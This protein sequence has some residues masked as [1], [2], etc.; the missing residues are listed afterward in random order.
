MQTKTCLACKV[1]KTEGNFYRSNNS[2]APDKRSLICVQCSS[3]LSETEKTRIQ[4]AEWRKNNPERSRANQQHGHFLKTY[5]IGLEE[6]E[7]RLKHQNGVCAI[8]K[9]PSSTRHQSGY[10]RLLSVDHDHSTG[11][12]RDLLCSSCNHGLGAF[13][14]DISLLQAAIEYLKKHE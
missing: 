2:R 9:K 13:K 7:A 6:Y 14:D 10:L 11:K 12:V 3:E 8:C 4:T 1:E 5:G